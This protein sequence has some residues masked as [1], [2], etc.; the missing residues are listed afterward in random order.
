MCQHCRGGGGFGFDMGFGFGGYGGYDDM[1]G[2]YGRS[3]PVSNR[4]LGALDNAKSIAKRFIEDADTSKGSATEEIITFHL[5]PD[6][7]K[8]FNAWAKEQGCS[9]KSRQLTREEQDKI[10]KGRKSLMFYTSLTVSAAAQ[11]SYLAK[12]HK[13]A[14]AAAQPAAGPVPKKTVLGEKRTANQISGGK[15]AEPAIKKQKA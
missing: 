4:A 2:H 15:A 3:A 12:H 11:A 9:A 5:V 8:S 14:A 6:M 1:G 10:N 7:R 13:P